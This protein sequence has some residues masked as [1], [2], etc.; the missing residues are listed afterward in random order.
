MERQGFFD[1]LFDRQS[2]DAFPLSSSRGVRTRAGSGL[3]EVINGACAHGESVS[4]SRHM[5]KRPLKIAK[6]YGFAGHGTARRPQKLVQF[7]A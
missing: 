6:M 1:T 2:K 5:C 4:S 3:R 7:I